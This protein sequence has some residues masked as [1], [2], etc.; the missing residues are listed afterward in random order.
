[1]YILARKY[2]KSHLSGKEKAIGIFFSTLL[3]P[4]GRLRHRYVYL[5]EGGGGTNFQAFGFSKTSERYQGC[6]KYAEPKPSSNISDG[7]RIGFSS[8]NAE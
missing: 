2:T 4:M 7:F 8:A 5:V 6:S 3:S 1:M